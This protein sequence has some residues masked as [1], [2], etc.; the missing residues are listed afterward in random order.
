[1]GIYNQMALRSPNLIL[2]INPSRAIANEAGI[3]FIL[4]EYGFFY[5][6]NAKGQKYQL[7]RMGI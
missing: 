7:S 4:P 5:R 6:F 2:K 3:S 1:M